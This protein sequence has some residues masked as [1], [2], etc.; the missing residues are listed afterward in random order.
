MREN[1]INL[2]FFLSGQKVHFYIMILEIAFIVL[3]SSYQASPSSLV[4]DVKEQVEALM[5]IPVAD[6]KLLFKGKALL[7]IH[8]FN[9]FFPLLFSFQTYFNRL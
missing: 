4:S 8:F 9:F 2:Q 5:D 6:Q 1:E 3:F 7:G